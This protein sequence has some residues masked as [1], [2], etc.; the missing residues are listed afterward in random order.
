MFCLYTSSEGSKYSWTG[1]KPV[2][3]TFWFSMYLKFIF[4]NQT[5]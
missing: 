2:S 5:T 4:P 3:E 1:V